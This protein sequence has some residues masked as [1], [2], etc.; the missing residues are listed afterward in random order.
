MKYADF[1]ER[2]KFDRDVFGGCLELYR[3][4]DASSITSGCY[5][6]VDKVGNLAYVGMSDLSVPK[7]LESHEEKRWYHT[8]YVIRD[9]LH[10]GQVAAVFM[11]KSLIRLF[12]PYANKNRYPNGADLKSDVWAARR[13]GI[14]HPLDFLLGNIDPPKFCVHEI[15]N[16][17]RPLLGDKPGD[18]SLRMARY[19]EAVNE[20]L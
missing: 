16:R 7:R 1:S 17:P 5:L 11:E 9:N 14:Q 2:W 3:K 8:A 13:Y 10:V 18:L 19:S 15:L 12:V 6:I 4:D 20:L